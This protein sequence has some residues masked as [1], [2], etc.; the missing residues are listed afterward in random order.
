MW[1]S[2]KAKQ[3]F[4]GGIILF[5]AGCFV[6]G[7]SWYNYIQHNKQIDEGE[8]Q[9]LFADVTHYDQSWEYVG[10][11]SNRRRE[12]VCELDIEYEYDDEVYEDSTNE[13]WSG[14]NLGMEIEIFVNPDD[15]ADY[16]FE[17]DATAFAFISLWM[18]A[19]GIAVIVTGYIMERTYT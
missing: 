15:P 17:R 3:V 10:T 4:I 7:V 16:F 14:I 2:D 13:C 9:Q 8:V 19:L 18:P 1:M 11:G 6:V 5:V 12:K